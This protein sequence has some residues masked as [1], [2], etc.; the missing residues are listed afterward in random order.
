MYK[1]QRKKTEDGSVEKEAT[2]GR[3]I[4]SFIR[5]GREYILHA[6]KGWRSFK[7]NK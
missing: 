3:H 6:T 7:V 2:N 4:K 5:D 1:I